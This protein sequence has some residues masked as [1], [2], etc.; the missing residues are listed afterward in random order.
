MSED[1]VITGIFRILERQNAE[2]HDI[3]KRLDKQIDLVNGL[4]EKVNQLDEKL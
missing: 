1:N 3:N 4:I 2:L